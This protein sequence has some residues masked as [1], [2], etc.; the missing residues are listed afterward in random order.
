[1]SAISHSCRPDFAVPEVL[2]PIRTDHSEVMYE[3]GMTQLLIVL[4]KVHRGPVAAPVAAPSVLPSVREKTEFLQMSLM[5]LPGQSPVDERL[6][7]MLMIN[8]PP[9]MAGDRRLA[10][11]TFGSAERTSRNDHTV[12]VDSSEKNVNGNE[13]KHRRITNEMSEDNRESRMS[14][15]ED[16]SAEAIRRGLDAAETRANS[17]KNWGSA[18]NRN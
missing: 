14:F 18:E 10:T 6:E 11:I 7:H 4:L 17:N 1:M 12:P 8:A 9:V 15:R 16:V 3:W 13:G 5:N 2:L